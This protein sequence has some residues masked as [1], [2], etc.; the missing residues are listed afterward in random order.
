MFEH[1]AQVE[2]FIDA[3]KIRADQALEGIAQAV[4][5]SGADK[6]AAARANFDQP[7]AFQ[8]LD[9]FAQRRAADG[10][11]RGQGSLARQTLAGRP[12]AAGY[13]FA[14]T[15]KSGLAKTAA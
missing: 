10:Q 6:E 12:F 14:Q 13:A 8:T 9:R 11:S 2:E 7:L 4:G 15:L 5:G 1:A 3:V